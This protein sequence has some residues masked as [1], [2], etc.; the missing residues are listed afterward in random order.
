MPPITRA[1]PSAR[2]ETS[3]KAAAR[4]PNVLVAKPE[5]A[6]PAAEEPVE[7]VTDP[8]GGSY[9][10]SVV[11]RGGTGSGEPGAR[12]LVKGPAAPGIRRAAPPRPKS[13]ITPPSDLSRRP[14][15]LPGS[16]CGGYYPRQADA[17]S[18]VVTVIAV[19]GA[20]GSAERLSLSSESPS[21]QGFGGAARACL[22]QSR[23]S[24][25][26]DKSGRPVKAVATVR[27][28]FTR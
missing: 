11:A 9:Q 12:A 10:G 7:F 18:A 8:N 21:G 16:G 17:D 25:A 15:M 3:P 4:A 27:V 24:P 5:A 13:D 2:T 23:F 26:L 20:S 22:R 19:V 6:P 14:T 28:R 1:E